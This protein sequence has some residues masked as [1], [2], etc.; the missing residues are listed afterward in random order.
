VAGKRANHKRVGKL[1][2]VNLSVSR[3]TLKAKP[4]GRYRHEI[5]PAGEGQMKALRA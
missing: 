1:E 3:K 5:R 4:Q 2:R